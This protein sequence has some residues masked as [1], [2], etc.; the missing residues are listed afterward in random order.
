[1]Q[2]TGTVIVGAGLAGL[3]A[4]YLLEKRGIKDIVLLEARET[5]GGRIASTSPDRPAFPEAEMAGVDLGPSWFWPGFQHQMAEL[6]HVLGLQAFAQFEQ[7]DMLIERSPAMAAQRVQ[8]FVNTPPSMR[9]KGG[10][11]A[12]TQTLSQSLETTRVL[13]SHPVDALHL[14]AS[15]VDVYS[16]D[17]QGER[18]ILQ[19]EQVLLA[20]PPRLAAKLSFSPALPAV[21]S[22]QWKNTPTWMA[23]HAKYV[24]LF[25]TPFWRDQGLSGEA[26]SLSGPLGEI[27]DA[28]MPDGKA[29]LFGFFNTPAATRERMGS[30]A[31]IQACRDQ[32]V[33]LFGSQAADPDHDIIKDWACEPYTTTQDDRQV[34]AGQHPTAPAN[35]VD[36]GDWSG[37]LIGI[38]SEWGQQFPGYLAGAVEAAEAGVS[39]LFEKM[40]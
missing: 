5:L 6:V 16:Q 26:R 36:N 14:E 4:A 17:A 32:L 30:N 24:A 33:R 35:K 12:L 34:S 1:M 10:M 15:H 2:K 9:L 3:Y 29:A 40:S 19:A 20:L 37:Y 27:H 11:Q 22:S 39:A 38:G 8:G 28:S 21:L 23:P 13:L 7:G 25:D 31:L 18:L